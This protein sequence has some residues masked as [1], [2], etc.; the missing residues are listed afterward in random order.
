MSA[1]RLA[2]NKISIDEIS[3]VASV[4]TT[5][6]CEELNDRLSHK[7]WTMGYYPALQSKVSLLTCLNENRP[8]LLWRRYGALEDICLNLGVKGIKKRDYLTKRVSRAATGPDFK[9]L[10]LGNGGK[11]GKIE[12][13]TLRIHSM[14]QKKMW[15][16]F[17]WTKEN[18]MKVFENKICGVMGS[19]AFLKSYP[20]TKLPVILQ[21]GTKTFMLLYFEG[22][23][24]VVETHY[25]HMLHVAESLGA[26]CLSRKEVSELGLSLQQIMSR[27][28]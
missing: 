23:R 15:G 5:I 22:M 9:R 19:L 6:S 10:F 21:K 12:Q 24:T 16:G 26:H 25:Y 28:K 13:A 8:N 20:K 14:P 2:K 4:S 27:E 18:P 17:Y 11:L 1:K 7:G 3:Q